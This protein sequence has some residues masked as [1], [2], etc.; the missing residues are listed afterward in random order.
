M[1][2]GWGFGSMWLGGLL[3]A[4]FWIAVI[5]AVV[6]LVHSMGNRPPTTDD[7]SSARRILDE[8]FASGEITED[9]YQRRRQAMSH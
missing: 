6:W 3:M 2:W 4:L 5:V 1:M 8:R 7:G 9:E